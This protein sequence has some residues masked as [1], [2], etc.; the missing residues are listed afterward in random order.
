MIKK[1]ISVFIAFL[2]L[3]FSNTLSA[4]SLS[5]KVSVNVGI[6]HSEIN[7]K[8]LYLNEGKSNTISQLDWRIDAAPC[9]NLDYELGFS[10]KYF[11]A[12]NGL[13]TFPLSKGSMNDYDWL[14]F[15][16]I[17]AA[18]L[19]HYSTHKNNLDYLYNT[20]LSAGAGINLTAKIQFIQYLSIKYSYLCFTAK[21]GY[22]QYGEDLNDTG[23]YT[24]W[25]ND[26]EKKYFSGKVIS[27][28]TQDLYFGLCSKLTFQINNFLKTELFAGIYPS[29]WNETLDTHHRRN[30][31]FVYFDF[32]SKLDFD[33]SLLLEY[34]INKSSSISTKF[35][36][37]SN[38]SNNAT[39]YQSSN[40]KTWERILNPGQ[41]LETHWS[42]LL[43][44][45]YKY[46][47]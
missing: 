28:E 38:T 39:V 23:V 24:P 6:I 43:G 29:L 1:R 40:K 3:L 15:Y 8:L 26:I 2:F 14:N 9:L 45:S 44:Y 16:S 32:S 4:Q 13:Y 47:Y 17:G 21:D 27:Y 7:E 10:N 19:T 12:L 31:K 35:C 25:S 22:R 34:N 36:F 18:D 41:A 20:E 42:F 30:E 33:T 11:I 46:D 5:S 37:S